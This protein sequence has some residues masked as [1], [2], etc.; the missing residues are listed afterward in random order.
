MEAYTVFISFIL[1]VFA[2]LQ[3]IL[4]FK[5]WGMTNDIRDIRNKYLQE[6]DVYKKQ[7]QTLIQT[8]SESTENNSDKSIDT[9][10][11]FQIGDLVIC[12]KTDKQMRVK[13]IINGK[14][15]CYSHSGFN[16]YFDETEIKLFGN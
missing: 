12:I 8:N 13:E 2:I 15:G 6:G 14:Y 16:G 10:T 4:F 5:I 3:I 11:K 9:T 7:E 1:F